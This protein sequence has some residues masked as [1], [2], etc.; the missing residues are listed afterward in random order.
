M[1]TDCYYPENVAGQC[2]MWNEWPYKCVTWVKKAL[3]ATSLQKIIVH[4]LVF[5]K[6]PEIYCSFSSSV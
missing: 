6:K 2:G 3:F 4:I 1:K 5:Q